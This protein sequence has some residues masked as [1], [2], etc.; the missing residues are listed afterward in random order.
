MFEGVIPADKNLTAEWV[1]SLTERG[2]P[3]VYRKSND[4]L[5]FIGMPVGGIACGLL[6]L[7]G[8]GKLWLWDI[9][10]E[11]REG[12][13]A[14]TAE[15]KG[16][17][18]LGRSHFFA[19]DGAGY[20]S[21]YTQ[22]SP[23]EQGFTLQI[24]TEK[25]RPLDQTGWEEITFTGQYP[26]GTV[27]YT[28]P[29]SPVA[30]T[31]EAFSPFIP[32][33]LAD[34]SLPV[35]VLRFVLTNT[36]EH[37][38]EA[39]LSGFLENIVGRSTQH[40]TITRATKVRRGMLTCGYVG[41]V[42][43]ETPLEQ[44]RDLGELALFCSGATGRVDRDLGTLTKSVSLAPGKRV[45]VTFILAWHFPHNPLPVPDAPTGNHYAARFSSAAH[46][47]RYVQENLPRLTRETFLWRDTFYNDSTLPHWFLERTFANTSILA[48]TTLHRLATGRFW[49]WEGIGCCPGTCTHVWHYAQAPGRLFPELERSLREHVDFGVG[50][51]SDTGMIRH[52]AEE[53][54][55]AVDGQCGRILGVLREHQMS[56]DS[57]LLTRLWPKVKRALEFLMAHDQDGDG[58]LDGAQENTLDAAWYGKIAWL[59]SLYAA[60]LRAGEALAT[61]QGEPEFAGLCAGRAQQT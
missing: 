6:Y 26:V 40:P 48:T 50:F 4:E 29:A 60:A 8:D 22:Q 34:S 41:A 57:Q 36:G 7:G 25:P 16:V 17:V 2:V 18:W 23:L 55:P 61:E 38:V 1:R 9:F 15:L 35:T 31:L 27:H 43:E 46:A 30:V 28:D 42:P 5:R 13:M 47:A 45:V 24:G 59:S 19:R 20:I 33:N 58:L 14:R 39:K 44:R 10:N 21:P 53:S 32:L 54:G 56:P 51:D 37:A 52:R 49:A 12:V 11:P 3:T